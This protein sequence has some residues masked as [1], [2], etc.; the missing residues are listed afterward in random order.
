M[1]SVI[2]TTFAQTPSPRAKAAKT[3]AP[4][5]AEA[6]D[7]F[8]AT[9]GGCHG[10]DGRG[11]ER[12]PNIATR[13]EV[14]RRS[15]AQLLG[16]LQKGMP[17]AGMPGFAALGNSKLVALVSYLRTLQGKNVAMPI[18]GSPERG[19]VLF[20]GTARCAECHMVG[21]RGGFIGSDLSAYASDSSP[22][23]IRLAIVK[24]DRD[25]KSGRGQ[26][27]VTMVDGNRL[28]GVVRNE[29]NF[30]MQ[31]QTLDGVFHFIQRPEIS[32]VK[33]LA[34]PIMP[35]DY[36]QSLSSAELDDIVGYLM[37]VARSAP[38]KA[39]KQKK[40]YED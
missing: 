8:A 18:I 26:V 40:G 13:Q 21:G 5:S 15:D 30:S 20:F 19:E 12:G 33:P 10:L 1:Y 4:Q 9:C 38:A 29:D 3:D 6:R 11:A 39:P 14:V 31:L 23:D 7:T 25:A 34:R 27:Q 24:P 22:T 32:A 35:A 17:A 16:I 37:T 28:E 36:G 2:W